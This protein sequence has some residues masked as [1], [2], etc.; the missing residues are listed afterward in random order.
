MSTSHTRRIRT[1]HKLNVTTKKQVAAEMYFYRESNSLLN[2]IVFFS[3]GFEFKYLVYLS[4]NFWVK[5]LYSLFSKNYSLKG[6]LR[7]YIWLVTNPKWI[8]EHR[9]LLDGY[10]KYK[11]DEILKMISGKVFEGN[12]SL[13]KAAN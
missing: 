8:R 12:N 2:F 6:L 11:Q 5:L 7:A 4:F 1:Y 13:E 3:A 10:K 9:V